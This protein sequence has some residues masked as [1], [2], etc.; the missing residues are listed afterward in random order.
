MFY[1]CE[2][3]QVFGL[4]GDILLIIFFLIT[5]YFSF[6]V[7]NADQ[8]FN[9]SMT[10]SYSGILTYIFYNLYKNLLLL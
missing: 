7:R 3:N 5:L 4:I 6:R 9:E 10:I 2:Y 8:E 1:S